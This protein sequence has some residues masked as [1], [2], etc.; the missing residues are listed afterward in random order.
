LSELRPD[1]SV[2]GAVSEALAAAMCA[3][4]MIT[5]CLH[6][7]PNDPGIQ[8]QVGEGVATD[9]PVSCNAGLGGRSAGA[10]KSGLMIQN[11]LAETYAGLW[12]EA[13]FSEE[14]YWLEASCSIER[15]RCGLSHTGF[16]DESPN[17]KGPRLRFERSH[18]APPKTFSTHHGR[19]IHPLKLGRLSVEEAQGAAPNRRSPLIDDE[20]GAASVSYLLGIQLEVIRS[21]LRVEATELGVQR[22]DQVT[23][24]LGGQLGASDRYRF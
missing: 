19:H 17:A 24:D 8:L 7:A 23:A 6:G 16:K 5:S 15:E 20:E 18:E 21:R 4:A 3:G 9:P 12:R 11:V 2:S 13:V 22:G 1:Q 10:N 14:G